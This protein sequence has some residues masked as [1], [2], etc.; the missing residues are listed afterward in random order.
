MKKV[1]SY[2]QIS[3]TYQEKYNLKNLNFHNFVNIDGISL[4]RI[5]E[6][7]ENNIKIF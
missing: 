1:K 2:H 6:I 5:H 7:I 3:V 4:N